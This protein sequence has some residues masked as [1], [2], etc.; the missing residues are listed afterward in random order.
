LVRP[1]TTLGSEHGVIDLEDT[2]FG[3]IAAIGLLIFLPDDLELVED[4]DHG[5]TRLREV[6]LERRQLRF[7]LP[8]HTPTLDS[9]FAIHYLLQSADTSGKRPHRVHALFRPSLSRRW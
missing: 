4:V 6:V 3:A 7:G 2:L 1:T 5:I 9:L 8:A